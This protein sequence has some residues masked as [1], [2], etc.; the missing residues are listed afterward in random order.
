MTV[1]PVTRALASVLLGLGLVPGLLP[2]P[3]VVPAA[4][5]VTYHHWGRAAAPDQVL[6]RGCRNYRYHY[7]VNAPT[8]SWLV[9]IFLVSPTGKGLGYQVLNSQDGVDPPKGRRHFRVCRSSTVP[10]RHKLRMK[11][12]WYYPSDLEHTPHT[13]W[14]RPTYFRLTRP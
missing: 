1:S 10:G 8:N 12:T 2:V 6:R 4:D 7:R 5:A 3:A 9:E 14:V 13:G 11:V